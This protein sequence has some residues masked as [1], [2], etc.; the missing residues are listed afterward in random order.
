MVVGFWWRKRDGYRFGRVIVAF[1]YSGAM[2]PLNGIHFGTRT[3]ACE[4]TTAPLVLSPIS[5]CY[6]AA[7]RLEQCRCLPGALP[8]AKLRSH[9]WC[10]RVGHPQITIRT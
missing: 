3:V 2:R 1:L 7:L 4:I 10:S 8:L 9:L 6:S 5:T